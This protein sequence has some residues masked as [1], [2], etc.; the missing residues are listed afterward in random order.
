M[1]ILGAQAVVTLVVISLLQKICPI[2]SLGRW[3][4]TKQGIMRYLHPTDGELKQL[5]S[6]L[7]CAKQTF[8]GMMP[9]IIHST[10]FSYPFSTYPNRS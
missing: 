10:R 6:E 8:L 7:S 9:L 5:S 2:Y 3:L 4:L 1:A